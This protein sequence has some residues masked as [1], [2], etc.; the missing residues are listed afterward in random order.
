[1]PKAI[2]GTNEPMALSAIGASSVTL[3]KFDPDG[4]KHRWQFKA[5]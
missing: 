4:L 3:S 2:P 5:P 1:M